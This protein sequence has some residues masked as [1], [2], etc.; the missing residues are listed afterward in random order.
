MK[1]NTLGW[2]VALGAGVVLGVAGAGWWAGKQAS[3]PQGPVA[4]AQ[5][6]K[7]EGGT[8]VEVAEVRLESMPRSATAVGTLRSK[9]SVVLRSEI[10]GRITEINIEEGG[11]VKRGDVV[12]RLDDS[13]AKAQV[14]QAQ[15]SLALAVSQDRRAGELTRQGFISK[16]ARDEAASQLQV[17]RAALALAKAQLQK[18]AI[19]APFDGLIGLRN[20]SV[21]DYVG[22]GD[23]LVPI[24]SVDPLQVDF[25]IPEQ[26]LSLVHPGLKL[27]LRFDALPGQVREGEVGAVSPSIDVGG[28]S[29]LLRANVGNADD[30]LRPGMFARVDLQFA[31][32]QVLTIPETALVP[33]GEERYVYRVAD[34]KAERLAVRIGQ[35]RG[36]RIEVTSGLSQGDEVVVAG[37]Q[38]VIDGAPVKVIGRAATPAES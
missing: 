31:D 22:P 29:I 30:A 14:Q 32:D 35:R 10:T 13:V 34:G 1:A 18:T 16:Q 9:D 25:R 24:E 11:K 28:R 38:K 20:V 3:Q 27:R 33:S 4:A 8:Q 17:Q 36:G 6:A 21:G 2:I 37:L 5:P 19:V 12:V 15:A 7:A 23:V 26:Y